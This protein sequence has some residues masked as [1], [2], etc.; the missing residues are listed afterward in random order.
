MGLKTEKQIFEIVKQKDNILICLPK[1]PT[2]DAIASG[3]ALFSVLEKMGKRVKT[4]A[5]DFALPHDHSFLPK[6]KEIF[7]DLSALRKFIITVDTSETQPDNLEYDIKDNKLSIYITPKNGFYEPRDVSTSAGD[8]AF[9]LIFTIDTPD[10]ES[11]GSIYD[12]NAEFFYHTPIVNID[13]NPANEHFGQINQIN[14]TATSVSEVI[15]E[16]LQD[17]GDDYLDEYIATNLLTGIISKTKSFK[18]SSV[19]PRSLAIASHLISQGARRDEIVKNLFQNKK[20][21]T[22]KLWGKALANLKASPEKKIV[23]SVLHQEDFKETETEEAVLDKV[24]DELIINTP[25]AE[26]VFIVYENREGKIEAVVATSH[27]I[28]AFRLFSEFN[29]TGNHDFTYL[30][31]PGKDLASAETILKDRLESSVK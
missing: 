3:L 22:L 25:D 15:F 17:W 10:L 8:F 12:N 16:L 24:I 20:L 19:T 14:V 29:P 7:A 27:Y 31:F 28:D 5:S 26:D 6:S 4:V 30:K 23:W 21:S 18:T 2:T 9:D 1:K 13:H 11:L